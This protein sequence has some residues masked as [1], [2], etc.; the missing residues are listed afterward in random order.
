MKDSFVRNT[1]L[2]ILILIFPIALAIATGRY[3]ILA[4][5]GVFFV[6]SWICSILANLPAKKDKKKDHL[7]LMIRI[8]GI[9]GNLVYA[10]A[11]IYGII[12]VIKLLH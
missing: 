4:G 12:A 1:V 8:I 6:C 9:F 10:V 11:I 3:I 5:L 2:S 7:D